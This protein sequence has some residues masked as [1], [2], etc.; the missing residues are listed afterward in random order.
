MPKY[1][2]NVHDGLGIT[3]DDGVECANRE[4]ALRTAVHYAGSLLKESGH[5]LSV[6]DTW[7]LEVIEEATSETFCIELRIRPSLTSTASEPHRSAA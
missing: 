6:G 2:F 4:A 1:F 5:R 7:S 3:D